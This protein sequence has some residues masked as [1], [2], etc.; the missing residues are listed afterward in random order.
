MSSLQVR[1]LATYQVDGQPS[2]PITSDSST[3]TIAPGVTVDLLSPGETTVLVSSDPTAPANALSSLVAAYNAAASELNQNHGSSGGALTG[4]SILI[5]LEQTL[6]QVAGY[7]GGSGAVQS[8]ADLGLTFDQTGQLSFN[9]SQF[10]S[11]EAANPGDVASFLG[12]VSGG[13]FLGAASS[14]L[15]RPGKFNAMVDLQQTTSTIQQQITRDNL[16]ISTDQTNINTLQGNLI[17][18]MD[19]ADSLISSLESQVSYFTGL[20]ADS[21]NELQAN[22][23]G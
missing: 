1:P 15:N 9:Q 3:V 13:G 11:V 14:V 6:H 2:T 22:T 21:Q 17:S 20:F 10:A 19:A 23:L 8:L 4:N 18:Q 7:T 5:S 12:S 16:Q